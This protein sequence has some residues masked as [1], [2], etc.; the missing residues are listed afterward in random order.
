MS[1]YPLCPRCGESHKVCE[2]SA[3]EKA[4]LDYMIGPRRVQELFIP[5]RMA[6]MNEIIGEARK[7]WSKGAAQK[8]EQD[9]IVTDCI[10]Y[11]N[12]LKPVIG[13]VFL[14]F[15]WVEP[16]DKRDPD[17][18]VAAK[19]FILDALQEMGI[20]KDDNMECISGW[21]ER[22]QVATPDKPAGIYIKLIEE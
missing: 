9:E 13:A 18:I 14:E 17:N 22:W 6:G 5:G 16:D 21:K 2:P 10:A 15:E 7:H 12:P 3:I 19:K 20:I 1:K 4:G 11:E 8:K